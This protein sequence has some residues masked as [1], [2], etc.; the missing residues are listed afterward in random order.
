MVKAIPPSLITFEQKV[1][2]ISD[3][4][5]AQARKSIPSHAALQQEKKWGRFF[6]GD[7]E[8]RRLQS[9]GSQLAGWIA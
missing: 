7:P 6:A 8:H 5:V 2:A 4:V 1:R 9:T 3:K